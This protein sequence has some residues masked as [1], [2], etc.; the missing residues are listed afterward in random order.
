MY[1][2][3]KGDLPSSDRIWQ[4]SISLIE[5]MFTSHGDY[6]QLSGAFVYSYSIR[7]PQPIVLFYQMRFKQDPHNL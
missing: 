2:K 3:I 1:Q 6:V 4:R 7:M 5:L